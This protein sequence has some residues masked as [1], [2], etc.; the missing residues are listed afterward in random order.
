MAARRHVVSGDFE[1][2]M[3]E[4]RVVARFVVEDAESVLPVFERAVPGDPRP[5]AA[6]EAARVFVDGADRTKLQRVASVD[7]HRAA[8]SAPDEAAR[9]AARCAGDAAAAAY[10][11]P[12]AQAS[13]VGHILRAAASAARIGELAAGG[14]PAVGDALLDRARRR[15]TPVLVDVL[16]RYPPVTGGGSRVARLMSTL[17][18]ALR[19]TPTGDEDEEDD[20]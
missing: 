5:R 20:S 13:Q 9:L 18:D 12:L 1:L 16:R 17:D 8:R 14:D 4:L 7:A 10:L 6:I 2:T 19:R 15:A 11:H 3:D